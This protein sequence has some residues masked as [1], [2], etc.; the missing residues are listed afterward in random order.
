MSF[1]QP[2]VIKKRWLT[3]DGPNGTESIPAELVKEPHLGGFSEAKQKLFAQCEEYAKYLFEA[4]K[5]YRE[6][7]RFYSVEF[8][9]GF[10]ARMSAPGYLDA[11]DW[12]VF[13]T[14][15]EAVKYLLDQYLDDNPEAKVTFSGKLGDHEITGDVLNPGD[16]FG[17]TWLLEIGG[18]YSP[19]FVVAEADS[20]EGAINELSGNDKY[21]HHIIIPPEDFGDYGMSVSAGDIIGGRTYDAPCFINLRGE[22]VPDELAEPYWN[23]GGEPCDLDHLMVYGQEGVRNGAGMPFPCT[24]HVDG[25]GDVSPIVFAS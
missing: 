11:T 16:W 21:K 25:F 6:N 1:M 15:A 4:A 19:I 9:D 12:A 14:E 7:D 2:Q 23:D 18:S 17:K 20:I 5:D 24:Y 10:G 3:I 22:I 13:D 8:V